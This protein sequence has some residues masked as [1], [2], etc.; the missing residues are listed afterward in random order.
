MSI[1][2]EILKVALLAIVPKWV[3]PSVC[4]SRNSL[5]HLHDAEGYFSEGIL[6]TASPLHSNMKLKTVASMISGRSWEPGILMASKEN[7]VNVWSGVR[8]KAKCGWTG[9]L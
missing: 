3:G 4:F 1:N 7:P 6:E 8:T 9:E 2:K 5:P